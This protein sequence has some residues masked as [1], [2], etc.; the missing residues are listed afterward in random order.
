[1]SHFLFSNKPELTRPILIAAFAGWGD[2]GHASTLA[3]QQLIASLAATK[4]GEIDPEEFYD[5]S[6]DRPWV[7]LNA[8]GE[9]QL[10]WPVNSVYAYRAPVGGLDVILLLGTEPGLRWRTFNQTIVDL[11]REYDVSL[12]VTLG[13][14]AAQISHRDAVPVSGWA[15]PN[16]LSEKLSVLGVNQIAYEGPTGIQ[17]ALSCALAD[18]KIPVASLWAA[19]PSFLGTTPNPKAA[20][21][22]LKRVDDAA[23]L[24]LKLAE[25]T[26]A[27]VQFERNVDKAIK[28]ARAMPGVQVFQTSDDDTPVATT[29]SK[30][31]TEAPPDRQAELPAA[32]EVVRDA[33]DFLRQLR[34]K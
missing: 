17:T 7:R 29:E 31:P 4:F 22:L 11:A 30:A 32:D 21:A 3:L 20:L 9:R 13:A 16:E 24:D 25:L 1:M 23:D 26:E 12:V 33:E 19:T 15:W 10:T 18:A 8:A 27:S 28:R 34:G 6:S 5:F 14:F 2:A